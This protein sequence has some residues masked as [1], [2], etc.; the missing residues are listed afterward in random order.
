[1]ALDRASLGVERGEFCVLLGASGAGK[2]TLLR[3]VNGLS[4]PTSGTVEVDGVAVT[5][6]T[7]ARV[8]TEV[9]MVHQQFNLIGRLTVLTNVLPGTRSCVSTPRAL[10]NQ[11]PSTS[12]RKACSLLADV[13]L[14][15]A[16]LYRRASQLSGGEQQR[17]AVA[18][19]FILDPKVVLAD[20]P[21]ASLDV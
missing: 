14:D 8:R 9:A 2:S 5:P 1:I 17:V 3:A 6:K 18:R 15:E 21:V 10:F 16:H 11:F 20:E 19:A 4:P 12:Q 7:L 13:G